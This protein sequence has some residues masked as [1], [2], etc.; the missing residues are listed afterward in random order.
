MGVYGDVDSAIVQ[1]QVIQGDLLRNDQYG[2]NSYYIGQL[3]GTMSNL[4]S[5][6]PI[7]IFTALFRPFIWEIGSPTMVI[8]AAENIVL[9]FSIYVLF[10]FFLIFY[11]LK[12]YKHEMLKNKKI[13]LFDYI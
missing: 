7:A 5:L 6:A 11:F 13:I 2:S 4:L 10:Y 3:D 1:A 9:I 8:S 12:I